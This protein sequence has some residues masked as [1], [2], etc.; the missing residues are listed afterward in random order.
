MM[1]SIWMQQP[2]PLDKPDGY[3]DTHEF[4]TRLPPIWMR[5]PRLSDE[6][7]DYIDTHNFWHE[8]PLILMHQPRPSFGR[9]R[10]LR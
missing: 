7:D 1:Q 9:A 5:Q 10:R 8:I 4:W 6:P 2:W 3:V